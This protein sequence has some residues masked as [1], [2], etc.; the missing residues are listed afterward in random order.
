MYGITNDCAMYLSTK[1]SRRSFKK[2]ALLLALGLYKLEYLDIIINIV[3]IIEKH[4]Y[5]ITFLDFVS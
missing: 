4:Q 3:R 1:K 2:K 5:H